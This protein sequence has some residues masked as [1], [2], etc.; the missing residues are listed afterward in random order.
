MKYIID[1]QD[2]K[3]SLAEDFFKSLSFIKTVKRLQTNEISNITILKSINDY[4]KGN[5]L[6]TPLNLNDLKNMLDNA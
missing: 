5:I 4:E 3:I 6:P 1:I 2:N